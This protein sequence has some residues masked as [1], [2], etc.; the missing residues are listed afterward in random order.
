MAHFYVI[1]SQILIMIEPQKILI[2]EK[3]VKKILLSEGFVENGYNSGVY[4]KEN[5]RV[6]F[7]Q[8]DW[9]VKNWL[10]IESIQNK[11]RFLKFNGVINSIEDLKFLLNLI[12]KKELYAH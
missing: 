4:N 7:I 5:F 1:L 6:H 3:E 9:S 11:N 12:M 2:M 10:T 8:N